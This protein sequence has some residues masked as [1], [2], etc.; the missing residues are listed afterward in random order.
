MQSS[1]EYHGH[2]LTVIT[3]RRKTAWAVAFCVDDRS[4]HHISERTLEDEVAALAE[5]E[6]R[7]RRHVALEMHGG[8]LTPHGE[9]MRKLRI[10]VVDDN[11]DAAESLGVIL[12]HW[13]YEVEVSGDAHDALAR[14]H[15]FRP[16][17]ILLDVGL[18]GMDG[19][20]LARRLRLLP[21][22]SEVLL[23]AV[24]GYGRTRDQQLGDLAGMDGHLTK[25]AK[26]D[27]LQAMLL[28]RAGVKSPTRSRAW[29]N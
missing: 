15:T 7:A 26:L 27:V 23:L 19:Y 16:E 21:R 1:F 12:G 2:R 8:S 18:P 3:V 10:L 5:G 17:A 6:E 29:A 13:G 22:G 25:P 14:W 20:E 4:F 9:G 11:L 24:T 28:R